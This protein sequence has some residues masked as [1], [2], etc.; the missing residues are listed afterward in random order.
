MTR[1]QQAQRIIDAPAEFKICKGCGSIVAAKTCRCPNCHAYSFDTTEE[2]IIALA[3][4]L[5]TRE[6][7][8]VAPGDLQ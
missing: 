4:E 8:S 1:H 3:K 7:S 6:A 5:A 2:R